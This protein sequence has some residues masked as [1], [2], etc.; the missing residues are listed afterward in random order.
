M[1]LDGA[2]Y[3][4]GTCPDPRFSHIEVLIEYLSIALHIPSHGSQV[5]SMLHPHLAKNQEFQAALSAG[6]LWEEHQTHQSIATVSQ[7]TR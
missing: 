1:G 2:I 4:L 5:C 7:V 6:T 3:A